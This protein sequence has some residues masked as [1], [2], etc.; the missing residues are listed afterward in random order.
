MAVVEAVFDTRLAPIG[1]MAE[2]R[3]WRVSPD[4]STP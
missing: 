4:V 2:I 3:E 1:L